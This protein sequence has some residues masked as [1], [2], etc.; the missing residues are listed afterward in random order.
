MFVCVLCCVF[1]RYTYAIKPSFT[2]LNANPV[3][4]FRHDSTL[5]LQQPAP[6]SHRKQKALAKLLPNP[7]NWLKKS[8]KKTGEENSAVTSTD[9]GSDTYQEL[10]FLD[11]TLD[12]DQTIPMRAELYDRCPLGP[13]RPFS[14]GTDIPPLLPKRIMKSE[15]GA[16][17]E[18]LDMRPPPSERPAATNSP[19]TQLVPLDLSRVSS[20]GDVVSPFNGRGM[21]VSPSLLPTSLCTETK[22][23][24]EGSDEDQNFYSNT[25]ESLFRSVIRELS[26]F[27]ERHGMEVQNSGSGGKTTRDAAKA[28]GFKRRNA[29][30]LIVTGSRLGKDR[31]QSGAV[32]VEGNQRTNQSTEKVPYTASRVQKA[33]EALDPETNTY[34]NMPAMNTKKDPETNT[35]QNMPAMNTNS[36]TVIKANEG[37][38]TVY[39]NCGLGTESED[40]CES[41]ETMSFGSAL[42]QNF[43]EPGR[44]P[45]YVNSSD[46][47]HIGCDLDQSAG[48]ALQLYENRV[49]EDDLGS[50]QK[51]YG[52]H[53]SSDRPVTRPQAGI[54]PEEKQGNRS[55]LDFHLTSTKA[56]LETEKQSD[57]NA[58]DETDTGTAEE[59][60]IYTNELVGDASK[61]DTTLRLMATTDGAAPTESPHERSQNY[62]NVDKSTAARNLTVGYD[63]DVSSSATSRV[64][65]EAVLTAQ[66]GENRVSD[67]PSSGMTAIPRSSFDAHHTRS[68]SLLRNQKS[69]FRNRR[70]KEKKKKEKKYYLRRN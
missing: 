8:L 24:N 6:T 57:T 28:L 35:Y 29:N 58:N 39:G 32:E 63:A 51:G 48:H 67:D 19:V 10:D 40:F 15:S 37:K 31:V 54:P 55:F 16:V 9:A 21:V 46:G 1:N 70:E 26:S 38:T 12:S 49:A 68:S 33:R 20:H 53:P 22:D 13:A 34:Q 30:S 4:C 61:H 42:Y 50:T 36:E 5:R 18:C 69:R 44:S 45:V 65:V 56:A 14:P 62:E 11:E 23:W 7:R 66:E 60:Y 52:V 17:N 59:L 2:P 47:P 41:F 25:T 43:T 3:L 64:S 27:Q